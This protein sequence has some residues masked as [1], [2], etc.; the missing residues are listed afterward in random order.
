MQK[1]CMCRSV[2]LTQFH[3][4]F[5]AEYIRDLHITLMEECIPGGEEKCLGAILDNTRANL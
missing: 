4:R 3:V 1:K 2:F 5:A